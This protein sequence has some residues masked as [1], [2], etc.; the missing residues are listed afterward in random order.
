MKGRVPKKYYLL[1]VKNTFAVSNKMTKGGNKMEKVMYVTHNEDVK[2]EQDL[3]NLVIGIIFRMNQPYESKEIVEIVN[4]WLKGSRFHD[5]I[6]L[7]EEKVESNLDF[8]H[9][10]DNVRCWNGIYYPKSPL[11]RKFPEEYY[12]VLSKNGAGI[13]CCD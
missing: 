1:E 8:L 7:I 3:Q 2:N 10:R 9:I 12:E 11:T 6:D 5:D 13:I 4:Y